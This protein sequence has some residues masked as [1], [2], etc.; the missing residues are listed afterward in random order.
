MNRVKSTGGT[1]L[2]LLDVPAVST[3]AWTIPSEALET[4]RGSKAIWALITVEDADIR[5]AFG[6]DA[7]DVAANGHLAPAGSSILLDSEAQLAAFIAVRDG[8]AEVDA[9]VAVTLEY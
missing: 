9:S 1:P 5:W 8:E 2:T 7:E 6:L 4:S 3:T